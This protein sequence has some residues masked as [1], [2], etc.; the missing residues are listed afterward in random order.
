ML[1]LESHLLLLPKLQVLVPPSLILV[2]PLKQILHILVP[3]ALVVDLGLECAL[4]L[5]LH[6]L[7]DPGCLQIDFL[8]ALCQLFDGLILFA[9]PQVGVGI[10]RRLLGGMGV[11]WTRRKDIL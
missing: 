5:L 6:L 4:L 11:G 10:G 7:K 2:Q 8:V 9:P 3:A 1:Y